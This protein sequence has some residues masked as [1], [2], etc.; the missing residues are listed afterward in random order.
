MTI[1]SIFRRF[2][3]RPNATRRSP[4]GF[5]NHRHKVFCV[6]CNKTGTTSLGAA[7]ES[8][9]YRL[10][11]QHAAERLIEDWARRDFSRL[12]T[13]CESAD[14]FQDVPF[15]LA[16]TYAALDEA[17]PNSKFIL[18]VR[19][20]AGEWFDSLTRF[21]TKLI[22]VGRLPT[23]ADLQEF[24]YL[25]P[26]WLW[27]A[28]KLIF[29]VDESTLYQRELYERHYEAHNRAV[30]EYF[31]NRPR[32]LLILNLGQPDALE[33]LCR[34]LERSPVGLAMPHLNRSV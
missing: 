23:A 8:L 25:E 2:L 15:S 30:K 6:G 16:N 28:H 13:Y 10:G 21:H 19:D 3:E 12:L 17:F 32:D 29:C 14:A 5:P 22:G 7:L 9:G 31:C 34:F 24:A 1:A 27:M 26:G 4:A 20:S 33:S 18:T 11:D